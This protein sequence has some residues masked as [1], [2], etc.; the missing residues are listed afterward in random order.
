MPN[1]ITGGHDKPNRFETNTDGEQYHIDNARYCIWEGFDTRATSFQMQ[2]NTN[3]QF[4][5]GNQWSF[6]EDAEA[7]F[8]D[9]SGQGR[10][11]IKVIDNCMK[12]I[13]EQY[14]GNAIIMDI[15]TGAE[16]LSYKAINRREELLAQQQ[17]FTEVAAQSSPQFA[18]YLKAKM[19]IG[20]NEQE[21]ETI[22][23]NLYTDTYVD[24]INSINEYVFKENKLK[25]KQGD[26]SL[27]LSQSG[28]VVFK[29]FIH[30]G[31]LKWRRVVPE[32]FFFDRNCTESDTSDA[33]FWGEFDYMTPSTMFERYQNLS[34]DERKA[35]EQEASSTKTVSGNTSTRGGRVPVFWTYWRDFKQYEYG[36]VL[37]EYG[38]P[39]CV[40]IGFIEEGKTKPRYTKKDILPLKDLTEGQKK[41]LKGKNITKLYFDI[42]KYCVFI[43]SE[44]VTLPIRD[45]KKTDI[46]LEYGEMPYPNTEYLDVSNVMPP[47]CVGQWNFN[48]G[49]TETNLSQLIN[50]QRII[51]RYLSVEEQ[52]VN[53]AHG[54]FLAY[55]KT[56][57]DPQTGEAELL[58]N[59]YQGKPT[60]VNARGRGINNAIAE[61]GSVVDNSTL[62]YGA[63]QESK[64]NSIDRMSGINA[65]LRGESQGSDQLVGVTQLQIQRGSLI[66]ESFYDTLANVF[67]QM[68]QA[69]ANVGKRVYFENPRKLAIILGDTKAAVI[70][71]VK[72]LKLEDFRIFVSRQNNRQEQI[73]NGNM[74]LLALSD[75]GKID[76]AQ[77]ADLYMRSTPPEIAKALRLKA[78]EMNLLALQQNKAM[79]QQ[80]PE[81]ENQQ[82]Q[83]GLAMAGEGRRQEKIQ[84]DEKQ[85][86]RD[87][88]MEETIMKLAA[89]QEAKSK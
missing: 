66:Q 54:K 38:Y 65:S 29:Y 75:R 70:A 62:V 82:A 30:N 17:Y 24:C 31:E 48:E 64:K 23:E 53:S 1:I 87:G 56:M 33:L 10:N 9:N 84:A 63:L 8:M 35:I 61:V 27:D 71:K 42:L 25:E 51:N 67:L 40:Q 78:K 44:I 57:I 45:K 6:N 26:A 5:R 15:T 76:D 72:D 21:T 4:V 28:M 41:I 74:V 7:F 49:Y 85:K 34:I 18:S 37:D 50:P 86:D 55:D 60:P 68:A 14:R 3:R 81:V 80:I 22:F 59:M 73:D 47:F 12:P 89:N 39:M 43:P 52:Q 2:A 77:F 83:E 69:T 32:R 58:N 88:K 36:Y 79:Q 19:S 13:V 16:A 11:R 46:V 20:D